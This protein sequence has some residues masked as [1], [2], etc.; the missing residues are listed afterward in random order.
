MQDQLVIRD[1]TL[2]DYKALKSLIDE[3]GYPS[4]EDEVKERLSV[5]K[6]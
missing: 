4:S 6:P 3:L 1:L 5:V 2:D